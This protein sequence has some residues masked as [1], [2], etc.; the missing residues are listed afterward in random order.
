VSAAAAAGLHA[1][2]A[3][4]AADTRG[5]FPA[6]TAEEFFFDP[7]TIFGHTLS[8]KP[9]GLDL[10]INRVVLLQF[11]VA[12]VLCALFAAAFRRPRTVPR[13]PQNLLEAVMDFIRK[14]LV[15]DVVGEQG[16]KYTAYFMAL[17]FFIWFGNLA[18]IVPGIAF[19][20]NSRTGL[21]IA[22]A[23]ITLFLFIREGVRVQGLGHYLKGA[24]FPPGVPL[25]IYVILT[26]I[27]FI[28]TFLIR[29]FTLFIRLAANM[30]AGHLLLGIMYVATDYLLFGF[31]FGK[32]F[33]AIF[34]VGSFLGAV[35]FTGFEL[36]VGSLQAYIFVLL[37]GVYIAG[38]LEPEH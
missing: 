37:T 28:S 15:L 21:P 26:P 4:P 33:T 35:I 1:A 9:G 3:L 18:E 13:G 12:G 2:L 25:P 32:A 34:G 23:L 8:F 20:I 30:I 29:P 31:H 24:L 36:F 6:P 38:A 27:E 22:F 16:K 7:V 10:S 19:P 11:L 5:G 14:D 17:F